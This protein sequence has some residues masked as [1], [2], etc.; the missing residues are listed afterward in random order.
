MIDLM[1]TLGRMYPNVQAT[2]RGEPETYANIIW[3]GGDPIPSEEDLVA[4][5]FIDE[6]QEC[7]ALIKA[8]RDERA[9]KGIT[10]G[11]YWFHSDADS[12]IKILG[13]VMLGQNIPAGLKWRTMSGEMVPMTP[14]LAQQVF[15]AVATTDTYNFNVAIN[16]ITAMKAMPANP[17]TYDYSSGWMPIYS[18]T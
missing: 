17:L 8:Y 9:N 10:A 5:S 7:D 13:L 3:E 12:R 6:Q 14:T 15:L 18:G 16:H 1:H 2:C 4:A 11:G